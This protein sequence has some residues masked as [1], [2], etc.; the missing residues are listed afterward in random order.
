MSPAFP[1]PPLRIWDLDNLDAD[2]QVPSNWSMTPVVSLC[3]VVIQHGP[4]ER[5]T[6]MPAAMSAVP[7]AGA[8]E[9]D[10]RWRWAVTAS[11]P[12]SP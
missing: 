7:D 4:A 11:G 1:D 6:A 10:E 3:E 5:A 12:T 2:A 9:P 8:T